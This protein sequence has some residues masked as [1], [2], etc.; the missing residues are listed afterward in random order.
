MQSLFIFTETGS[1]TG[2]LSVHF[3][4]DSFVMLDELRTNKL[5]PLLLLIIIMI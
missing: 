3:G 1:V 5:S 4:R 2:L